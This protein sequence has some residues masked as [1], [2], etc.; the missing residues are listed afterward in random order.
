MKKLRI[1]ATEYSEWARASLPN[2]EI[3]KHMEALNKFLRM[4]EAKRN[5]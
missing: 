4:V 5:V 1:W 3:I 2:K